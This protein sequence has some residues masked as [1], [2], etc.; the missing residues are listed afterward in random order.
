MTWVNDKTNSYH[1]CPWFI[2]TALATLLALT[3]LNYF[4]NVKQ[5]KL[6][7]TNA[8]IKDERLRSLAE[9]INGITEIKTQC[10][11]TPFMER[12][13]EMRRHEELIQ[14]KIG[15]TAIPGKI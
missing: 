1:P 10:W 12:N 6:Q 4:V 2:H 15:F 5:K 8:K 9:I 13:N 11:E 7:S 14:R 3:A